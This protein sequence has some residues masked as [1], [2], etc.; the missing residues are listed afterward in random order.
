MAR[1]ATIVQ[2]LHTASARCFSRRSL[3]DLAASPSLPGPRGLGLIDQL[4]QADTND[5]QLLPGMIFALLAQALVSP[6]C[7]RPC[8]SP[9]NWRQLHHRFANWL[10]LDWSLNRR[11]LGAGRPLRTERAIQALHKPRAAVPH[12]LGTD[13]QLALAC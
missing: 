7:A 5:T 13:S 4:G 9:I 10:W 11:H 6:Q 8:C 12:S 3:R 1:D 2:K